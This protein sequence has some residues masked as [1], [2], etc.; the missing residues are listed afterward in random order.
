MMKQISLWL[1]LVATCSILSAPVLGARGLSTTIRGSLSPSTLVSPTATQSPEDVPGDWNELGIGTGLEFSMGIQGILS[2]LELGVL[3]T[4]V[5]GNKFMGVRAKAMSSLTWATFVDEDGRV[6][7]CH[8]VVVGGVLTFGGTSPMLH[9][10]F[11]ARGGTDIL[12][13]YTFTPYD[14]LV[15]GTG[16]LIGDN[17]TFGVTGFFGLELFTGERAS[18]YFDAGGGF[19]IHTGDEDNPYVIASS[20][21]GSGFML[22]L[23]MT[24]YR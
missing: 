4:G 2:Y 17:V 5:G 22:R 15:Y 1:I 6:V 12:L 21:L 3:R 16:N 18:I 24:F 10:F 19:K 14:N 13:G 23:G 9:D 7:S 8:P 11:R 20:W